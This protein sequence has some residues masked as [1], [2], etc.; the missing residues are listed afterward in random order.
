M[1]NISPF[2]KTT[3]TEFISDHNICITSDTHILNKNIENRL[4]L[5]TGIIYNATGARGKE[6]DFYTEDYDLHSESAV[7][8]FTYLD[9]GQQKGLYDLILD[10]IMQ[11]VTLKDVGY[12][13]DI[14]CGKGLLL[15]RFNKRLPNWEL[16]AVEPSKNA[17]PFFKEVMPKLNVFNGNF[18]QSPYIKQQFNFVMANGVLEHVPDPFQFMRQFANCITD[19]GYGFIGVP[20]FETNP[21]D[22]FTY[23]HLSR[24]TIETITYVFESAGLKIANTLALNTRVPMWFVLKK[25]KV[26]QTYSL[27]RRISKS[28]L[29]VKQ[30]LNFI[31]T[32]FNNY[33]LCK[34]NKNENDKIA[35]YGMGAIGLLGFEYTQLKKEDVYCFIDDN[36]TLQGTKKMGI[37]VKSNEVI[38]NEEINSIILNCNPCY[39]R[40]ISHKVS[41]IIKN[42][43]VK[44]YN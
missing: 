28:R 25:E 31:E 34:Q 43:K 24:F 20:N 14:G 1:S 18:D 33:N 5:D 8:E 7:S 26:N 16:Y 30:S 13:L 27:E 19:E 22:L 4:C 44:F 11:T 29:L 9:E 15:N 17:I 6:N 23:D 38:L 39:V 32:S 35:M 42:T 36:P 2:T 37:H 10:F 21:T 3:N 41:T 12:A 40:A